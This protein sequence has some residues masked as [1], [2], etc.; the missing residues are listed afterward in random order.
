MKTFLSILIAGGIGF[1]A[2]Y[3]LVS[4]RN[5]AALQNER[6]RLEALWQVEKQNLE[7]DLAL[8]KNRKTK[9]E[10]ITTQVAVA[11]RRS[12]KE[13]L[14][15]LLK[16]Q[17]SGASRIST[18]RKIVH[19]LEDLA[20]LKNEAV[21]DIRGFLVKNSDLE[22]SIERG[23]RDG[24]DRRGWTPFWQRSAPPTEFTLPPSL[25]IGLFDVLKD[26][27]GE[28]AET[29]MGEVLSSSGRAVEVAYLARALEELAP[30]KYR[31]PAI[32]AA[33]DLL[34]NPIAINSPNRLDEQ[35]EGYLYG[36]L[37]M[38]NDASFIEDAKRMLVNS[39]GRLNRNAQNYLAKVQGENM[40]GTYYDLY[41]NDTMTNTF[42]KMSVAN[43]ILDYVGP[44]AQANNFLNEVVANTNI[45]SQM[46]SFA[47]MRLAGGFGGSESPTEPNVIAARMKILENMKVTSTDGQIIKTATFTLQNLQNLKDGKPIESPFGRGRDRGGRGSPPSPGTN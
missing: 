29:L 8:A 44:N 20:E 18:I 33:K 45:D 23:E 31:D 1:A 47:V 11:T 35:A 14:D 4:N 10:Q 36:V 39:E 6:V 27:G 24:G 13:I 38:Y 12:A 22:Y 2:A 3:A 16:L 32:S 26:I 41:K 17:P 5:D 42:D 15:N 46:R 9:T 19:E 7:S 34:R 21:P 43:R 37:E 30:G 28:E 40:V 25:R